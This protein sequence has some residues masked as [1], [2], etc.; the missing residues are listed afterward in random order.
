MREKRAQ[1]KTGRSP[2][3]IAPPPPPPPVYAPSVPP[4]ASEDGPTVEALLAAI[5][6]VPIPFIDLCDKLNAPPSAVRELIAECHS[7]NIL[8]HVENNHV[9]F[10]APDPEQRVQVV[11]IAPVVGERQ[12][13]GVLSDT[14][15]G[16]KYCLREQLK[17]FVAYAYSQGVREILHAGDVLDGCYRHGIWEVSHS[18]LDAQAEDL[19]DTLPRMPG[20]N[21]RCITGNHDFTFTEGSGVDVGQYLSSVFRSRGRT[22]V[23]FYGDRGAFLKVGGAVF[24]LW[25][26]KSG[27][28]YARSYALQKQ[29]EKYASGEKPNVLLA[30]HWHVYCHIFERGVHALACPT[31]QGG[32][33]AFA[34]SLGGAPAI[35]GMILSW[36]LTEHATLRSFI[37][38]YRAYFEVERPHQ[39]DDQDTSYLEELPIKK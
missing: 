19:F 26:P 16:S 29:V 9:G 34:K 22:D 27:V 36:D 7:R 15:L 18:G 12:K 23:H 28:A 32:G 3:R 24:H 2:V 38:E 10:R 31:F 14:H 4:A 1:A 35:G 33:S 21:Y 30:G 39:I 20:L 13:V 5:R 25:H 6:K 11:G 8:V 37:H 17:E